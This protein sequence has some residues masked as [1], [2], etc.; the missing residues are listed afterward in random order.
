MDERT[1]NTSYDHI[2]AYTTPHVL[3]DQTKSISEGL[4]T[5]LTQPTI[6]KGA[7][8]TAI[9][10]DKEEAS[11]AI[12]GD[13]EEASSIIKLEDLAKLVSQIHPRFKDLDSP[14]D[15][16]VIIVDES[17]EDELNA[18]TED[19]LVPRSLSPRSSQIQELMTR[20]N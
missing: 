16:H 15:D 11:T 6:E 10:G 7:S 20:V 2:F 19:T 8:F 13:N 18:K 5:V 17:D 14:E 1:K 3:A 12:H 9:H 4:E